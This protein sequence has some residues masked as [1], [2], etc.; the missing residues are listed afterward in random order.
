MSGQE[1]GNE[2][3]HDLIPG[4]E[5]LR[6]LVLE[7]A[8]LFAKIS[9]ESRGLPLVSQAGLPDVKRRLAEFDFARPRATTELLEWTTR[10]MAELELHLSD[11]HYFGVFN[12]N[13]SAM[14][15][16]GDFLASAF[17]SQLA[18]AVS[19]PF[20]VL[21]EDHLIAFFGKFLRFTTPGCGGIFTSGGTEANYTAVLCA[22]TEKFPEFE[23]SGLVGMKAQPVIYVSTETH[24]SILKAAKMVGLGL[25]AVVEIP[26]TGDQ[27]MDVTKLRAR[28]KADV[29][30]GRKPFLVVGTY[31]TTSTGMV[32]PLAEIAAA[33]KAYG[34]WFHVDAAWGGA[35]CLLPEL[36]ETFA[37][38][39]EAD[40]LTLDAHK[41]LNVPMT[42]GMFFARQI[43]HLDKAFRVT[44]SPY[45]PLESDG[46]DRTI[47]P[48]HRSMAWSRRLTGLKLFLSLAHAGIA[49]F[50]AALRH[51]MAMGR[52]LR[53]KLENGEWTL[54]SHSPLPVVCFSDP[55]GK[56]AVAIAAAV[57]KTGKAWV[58]TTQLTSHGRTV[59]RAGI[60]NALTEASHLD[61]LVATLNSAR[62]SIEA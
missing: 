5:G 17:N 14:G 44:M 39:A 61:E 35:A 22:L 28:M 21:V 23:K 50:Q 30:E 53:E 51:Q 52:V 36:A 9:E 62:K 45:M 54:E 7:A 11:P 29:A 49:G 60:S 18:S 16:V 48:Y 32:E 42:A 46:E 8:T 2:L 56:D 10:Q 59:L 19:S 15:V 25:D 40:S 47:P 6:A 31:G 13:P 41:W 37:P 55:G 43:N 58:T 20:G 57:A 33:A 27:T 26:V 1:S 12:P 38:C 24:H 3:V 34:C 4:P